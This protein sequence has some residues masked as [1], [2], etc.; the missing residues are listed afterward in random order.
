LPVT[1]PK[2]VQSVVDIP[3]TMAQFERLIM[4]D[5]FVKDPV[6]LGQASDGT[7]YLVYERLKPRGDR[8]QRRIYNATDF[9]SK[10]VAATSSTMLLERLG[11]TSITIP[12]NTT[13]A[14]VNQALSP[15]LPD[16]LLSPLGKANYMVFSGVDD[17][18]ATT[19]FVMGARL[20]STSNLAVRI[21]RDIAPT[22]SS[23]TTAVTHSTPGALTDYTVVDFVTPHG[24]NAFAT[25]S[26]ET[27]THP[28]TDPGHSHSLTQTAAAIT[29]S[30]DWMIVHV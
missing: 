10:K 5:R 27:S 2:A 26:H 7:R 20:T 12:A 28:H 16:S 18:S 15:V 22:V 30:L 24:A 21:G 29:A 4:E 14:F 1:N 17:P 25:H 9:L 23:A 6:L 3:V 8:A 19:L 11:S 13:N